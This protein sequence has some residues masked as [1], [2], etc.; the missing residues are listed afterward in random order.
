MTMEIRPIGEGMGAE[1]VGVDVSGELD[2]STFQAIES[3]IGEHAVVVVREQTL[4]AEEQARFARRFGTPQVNVRADAN[5]GGVAEV[6]WVSNVTRD[7]KPLGSHDA[8]RYWHSDLCYL[9]RPS[10]LTLLYALEVPE[11]DGVVYGATAFA[12]AHLAFDALPEKRKRELQG[13]RAANSYRTMWK[14]KAQEFGAREVLSDEEL[15]ARFPPDAIHPIVRVHPTTGRK[16]LYVCDGYTT[17]IDGLSEEA[18][19]ALLDELFEHLTQPSFRYVHQWR[20]GDVLIWDN[21]AVQHKATFDYQLPLRRVM[22]RC[23]IEG[24]VPV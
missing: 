2:T 5:H 13:L 17:H 11:K 4:L 8:G 12:G 1:I 7:G 20:I 19:A 18:S 10:S 16:C 3:A 15:A 21:C 14:R 6:F 9:E 24:S 23:T 22:R